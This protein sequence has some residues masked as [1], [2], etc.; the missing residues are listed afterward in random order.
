MTRTEKE[1]R[2][3]ELVRQWKTTPPEGNEARR[4]ALWAELFMLFF[5]LYD[6]D[7]P[8][9]NSQDVLNV[10]ETTVKNYDPDRGIPY[11]HYVNKMMKYRWKDKI[12]PD[13]VT[14]RTAEGKAEVPVSF[15]DMETADRPV[16][17]EGGKITVRLPVKSDEMEQDVAFESLYE[18]LTALILNFAECRRG[19]AASPQRLLWYR[20]F[21]T[22]DM[23]FSWKERRFR[24]LHERD[25][26]QA[27]YQPYL[28]YY[29]S[30]PCHSGDEVAATPLKRYGEVVPSC[31]TSERWLETK[32]PLPADVSLN[33][34]RRVEGISKG[35]SKSNRA[36]LLN[37]YDDSKTGKHIAGYREEVRAIVKS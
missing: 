9:K 2:L 26:F 30:R 16:V 15:T 12:T 20:L 24:Y 21:Y 28:D 14:I 32:V 27:L 4:Q 36:N 23:T 37:G 33:Y 31:Q 29:M 22:E 8:L 5:K 6:E 17:H 19:K 18:D 25:V 10:F 3:D 7:G 11:T 34:L 1:R 13:T 35:V